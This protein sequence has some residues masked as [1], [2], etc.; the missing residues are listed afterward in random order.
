MAEIR[1]CIEHHL[2]QGRHRAL[3]VAGAQTHYCDTASPDARIKSVNGDEM[4]VHYDGLLFTIQALVGDC[5]INNIPAVQGARIPGSCVVTLGAR[6]APARLFV[7]I[8]VSHPEVV[9]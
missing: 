5:F 3:I 7:T 1:R 4:S 2:V 6:T 9:S 8:D